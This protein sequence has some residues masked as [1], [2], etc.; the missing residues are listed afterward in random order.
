MICARAGRKTQTAHHAEANRQQAHSDNTLEVSDIPLRNGRDRS[1]HSRSQNSC[2]RPAQAPAVRRRHLTRL[3]NQQV[4]TSHQRSPPR[5]HR[6]SLTA[7]TQHS[8]LPPSTTCPLPLVSGLPH[9]KRGP[10]PQGPRDGN[11]KRTSTATTGLLSLTNVAPEATPVTLHGSPHAPRRVLQPVGSSKRRGA[12]GQ[13]KDSAA[14][15]RGNFERRWD[16]AT[17]R[18]A[19]VGCKGVGTPTSSTADKVRGGTGRVG[20]GRGRRGERGGARRASAGTGG[21]HTTPTGA[22]A[23]GAQ[24]SRCGAPNR[25]TGTGGRRARNWLVVAVA[26]APALWG[27]G[28]PR[29]SRP[30]AGAGEAGGGPPPPKHHK[31]RWAPTAAAGA[32]PHWA[33]SLTAK[34]M[35]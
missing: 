10:A 33:H 19:A 4:H 6:I 2:S 28:A 26:G 16:P 34:R 8:N 13:K 12:E 29:G 5:H 1:T 20:T 27:G 17:A 14:D 32:P 15:G 24:Q 9:G 22:P 35:S 30:T 23:N 7:H 11:A 25:A 31:P 21:G 3:R 18:A